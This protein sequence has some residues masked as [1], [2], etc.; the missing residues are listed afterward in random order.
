[1]YSVKIRDHIMIAHSLEGDVFGPAQNLHGATYV[2]DAVFSS[3]ELN[4]SNIVLDIGAA[5]QILREVLKPLNYQNLDQLTEF[6]GQITTT[7]FLAR[8]IH[9]RLREKT[10]RYFSGTI[11]VILGESHTAWA[12][13]T[14]TGS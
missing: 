8:Y 12:S 14:G 11:Q 4:S 5:H 13:Y 7:E 10:S 9:D 2:V 6:R 3:P 1:M